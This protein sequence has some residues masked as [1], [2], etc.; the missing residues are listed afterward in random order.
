MV[1]TVIAT[2]AVLGLAYTFSLGR[3]FINRFEIARAALNAA[4]S[5]LDQLHDNL[6]SPDFSTDSTH[7]RPFNHAGREVG[8]EEWNVT[9][10]DDPATFDSQDL[11]RVQVVVSWR[12]GGIPDTVRLSRLF[13]VPPTP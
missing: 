4:E 6:D 9:W 8:L 7:V 1:A 12:L 2:V 5:R 3:G 10:F 13:L 11:K